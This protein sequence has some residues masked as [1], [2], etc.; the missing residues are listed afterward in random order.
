MNKGNY[1]KSFISWAQ[2]MLF[3]LIMA[4]GILCIHSHKLAN[5]QI[6]VHAHPYFP[7]D[8]GNPLPNNH[9]ANELIILGQFFHTSLLINDISLADFSIAEKEI[10]TNY[11]ELFSATVK[12]DTFYIHHRGPPTFS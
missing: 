9:D 10:S 6:I 8:D 2:L 7:Q 4:N 5:G 1:I 11:L 3:C 12:K